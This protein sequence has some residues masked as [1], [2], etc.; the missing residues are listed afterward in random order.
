MRIRRTLTPH[1]RKGSFGHNVLSV[2]TGSAVALGLGVLTAPVL[3]RLYN[4]DDFGTYAACLSIANVVAVAASGRYELAIVQ[5]R[6]DKD[7][8]SLLVL[9]VALSV[10]AGVILFVGS[11]IFGEPISGWFNVDLDLLIWFI[12]IFILVLSI[13]QALDNWMN[14]HGRYGTLGVAK[15]VRALSTAVGQIGLAIGQMGAAGLAVGRLVA[16]F[17]TIGWFGLKGRPLAENL[18]NDGGRGELRAAMRRH[19]RFPQFTL[20]SALVNKTSYE[21]P[22]ILLIALFNPA[23]AGYYALVIRMIGN[24]VAV[25]SSSVGNV[26]YQRFSRM[27]QS[28]SSEMKGVFVKV[29]MAVA[30]LAIPLIVSLSVLSPWIVRW[31]FGSEWIESVSYIRILAP[32]L[33]VQMVVRSTSHGLYALNK[34]DIVLLWTI[35]QLLLSAV[36]LYVGAMFGGPEIAIALY[37]ASQVVTHLA[38]WVVT[39]VHIG[40]D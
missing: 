16:E 5:A 23:V 7:A 4:P 24:P 35:V 28:K 26:F 21:L 10:V 17:V 39:Y 13:S 25:L 31:A 19:I 9:C 33:I 40:K 11:V 27:E 2:A 6:S 37:A 36:S 12:P 18:K 1:L 30:A 22:S 15:S 20:P 3:T 38:Y 34:Q 14:Y 32:A 8:N 29:T